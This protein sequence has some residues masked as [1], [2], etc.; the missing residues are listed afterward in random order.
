M[1]LKPHKMKK[2]IGLML[3][4]LMISFSVDASIYS[5]TTFVE[6][7]ITLQIKTGTIF[8]TLTT[9]ARFTKIPVALII[10]GSGPMDRDGNYLPLGMKGNC[11][12][13]LSN[14][15]LKNGIATLRYD[16]RGIAESS[17]AC[18]NE[19]DIKFE[20]FIDDAKGLVQML[21]Q[22]KRFSKVI[23]IGHS[24]GSL[25]GM[26]AATLADK[27]ISLAGPGQTADKVLKVQINQ[28]SKFFSDL[29]LPILDS[30]VMGKTVAKVDPML[31]SLFKASLQP[32][33]ISWFKYDPQV[34]I[35]KLK[36][37]V[38]ILQGTS[39]LNVTAEDAKRLSVAN[40]K[41]NLVLI[42]NMNHVFRIVGNDTQANVKSYSDSSLPI[43]DQ[44]VKSIT[45]FIL[46]N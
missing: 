41:A 15:L 5:D 1:N 24:E 10:V 16:K 33:L 38:L 32:Y 27:Y 14:E 2:T 3:L 9:P 45:D 21:K 19:I 17:A 42:E 4:T 28:Q 26:P 20:D 18:K 11:Y 43:S 29:A 44:L 8:G 6:K 31:N 13:M 36:I 39:D 23:V 7:K 46:K 25:I 37:P 30:L 35:S 34:E 12:K 40:P 22:D